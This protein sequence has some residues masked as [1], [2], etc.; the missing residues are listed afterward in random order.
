MKNYVRG[1]G[2]AQL[3]LSAGIVGTMLAGVGCICINNQAT[4]MAPS[5]GGS[6]PGTG[7][8]ATASGGNLAPTQA[9]QA[10]G[11][12]TSVCN[13]GQSVSGTICRFYPPSQGPAPGENHFVGYVVNVGTGQILSNDWY[14]LQWTVNIN[15]LGCATPVAG[16]STDVT[17]PAQYPKLYKLAAHFK[18][19]HVP[20]NPTNIIY[21]AWVP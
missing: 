11:G 5:A 16:S 13:P 8:G 3:W 4:V 2:R 21:G 6:S 14:V 7:G 20:T 17:F 15:E 12:P 1:V 10:T 19:G 18:T 9:K